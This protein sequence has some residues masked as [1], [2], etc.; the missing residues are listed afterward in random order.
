MAMPKDDGDGVG[1]KG[2]GALKAPLGEPEAW[3]FP[4]HTHTHIRGLIRL[5]MARDRTQPCVHKLKPGRRG[6]SHWL[7]G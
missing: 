1:P 3:M 7:A 4:V 2:E 5:G 6:F